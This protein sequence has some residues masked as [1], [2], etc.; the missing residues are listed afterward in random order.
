MSGP[1]LQFGTFH[2]P[3]TPVYLEYLEEV[4]NEDPGPDN[5][6]WD[7]ADRIAYTCRPL[8]TKKNVKKK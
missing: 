5:W 7:L 1:W 2:Q 8:A 6:A 3:P 4:L